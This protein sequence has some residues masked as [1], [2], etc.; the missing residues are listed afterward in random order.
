MSLKSELSA[1]RKKKMADTLMAKKTDLAEMPKKIYEALLE[2]T[3]RVLHDS[4]PLA[5]KLQVGITTMVNG[6]EISRT[7]PEL[8]KEKKELPQMRY[9]G[10]ASEE[11]ILKALCERAKEFELEALRD[12]ERDDSADFV[13]ELDD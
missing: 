12:E 4:H 9:T 13:L 5:R 1:D 10:P 3:F 7:L 2:P 8:S 11:E 6:F